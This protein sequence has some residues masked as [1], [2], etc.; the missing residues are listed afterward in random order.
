M[1]LDARLLS[2]RAQKG[3]EVRRLLAGFR[4]NRSLPI[5]K[6]FIELCFC[7]LVANSNLEQTKKAWERIGGGFLSLDEA[8][9][10]A[11]LRK[12]GVRFHNRAAYI[13]EAR[14]KM[15][16]LEHALR[17]RSPVRIREWLHDNIKGLGWKESSHFL[18]NLGFTDF[19]ILDTHVAK[20]MHGYGLIRKTPKS[21]S[22]EKTY[23]ALERILEKK[24]KQLGMSMAGTADRSRRPML[25]R[26]M[27]MAEL[28]CYLFYIDSGKLPQK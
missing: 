24:A 10:Q 8:A 19:A 6:K 14:G 13:I 3:A 1:D 22:S 17:L 27:S 2:A 15:A 21:L 28:D 5:R 23:L 20:V 4:R 25:P 7:I 12:N 18:R 11:A 16:G 26:S 9:L